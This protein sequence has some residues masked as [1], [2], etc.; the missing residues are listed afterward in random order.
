MPR[1]KNPEECFIMLTDGFLQSI[2]VRIQ[3]EGQTFA[4]APHLANSSEMW[5][6]QAL[7]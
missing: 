1:Q 3:T 7:W 6:T 4:V 5:G 2:G